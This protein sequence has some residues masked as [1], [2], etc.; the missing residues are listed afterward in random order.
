MLKKKKIILIVFGCVFTVILLYLVSPVRILVVNSRL[1]IV[2]VAKTRVQRQKG[3]QHR[4]C[5]K[6]NR[7]MLFIFKEE[8]FHSFWMKDTYIPLDIAFIDGNNTIVDIQQMIPLDTQI[9][10]KPAKAA[11]YALEV[12]AGWMDENNIQ[13]NDKV[14]FW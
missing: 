11:K 1:I 4:S 13:I 5:L 10:Y 7:G 12:N 8:D 14:L 9:R 6:K 2:E 3:L